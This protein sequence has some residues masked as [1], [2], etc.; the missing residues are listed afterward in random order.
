MNE[1]KFDQLLQQVLRAPTPAAD[2][3]QK[4]LAIAN[5][6]PA[7]N[8]TVLAATARPLAA[9]DAL[10]RR[11]LPVAACLGVLLILSDRFQPGPAQT[12]EEEI[13]AHVYA[14]GQFLAST[15]HVSLADVN[16]RMGDVIGVQLESSPTTQALDVRWSKDCLVDNEPAMHLIVSGDTGPVSLMIVHEQVVD[17]ELPINDDS[18]TGFITPVQGGTLV[19]LGNKQEPVRKYLD[20]IDENLKW[21]Y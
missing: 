3:Q 15:N 19:V 4:L 21:E 5:T 11:A 17:K 18:H 13:L 12:I 2:L 6:D 8:V 7:D 1:Q 9:N 16:A 14:E 20:L 10:W